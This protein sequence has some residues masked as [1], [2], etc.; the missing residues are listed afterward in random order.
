MAGNVK[1]PGLLN[2]VSDET[3]IKDQID[4]FDVT[5]CHSPRFAGNFDET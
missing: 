1:A 4:V 2:D 5:I 3:S